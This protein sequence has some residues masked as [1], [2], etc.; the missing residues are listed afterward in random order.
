M[1]TTLHYDQCEI[2]LADNLITCS[3]LGRYDTESWQI[4]MTDESLLYKKGWRKPVHFDT[5][6]VK[7]L[8]FEMLNGG[9]RYGDVPAVMAYVVRESDDNPVELFYF[10]VHQEYVLLNQTKAHE[11][12]SAILKHIGEKYKVPYY[13]KLSV[14]TKEKQNLTAFIPLMIFIMFFI[15][16]LLTQF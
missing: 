6:D 15:L 2:V 1:A 8:Q 14:D 12:C 9:G 3:Y 5:K 13:Y 11:F 10:A 16:L 4:E 7:E